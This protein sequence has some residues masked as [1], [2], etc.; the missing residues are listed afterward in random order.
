VTTV[1]RSWARRWAHTASREL[2]LTMVTVRP[3]P[4][5]AQMAPGAPGVAG[6][7]PMASTSSRVSSR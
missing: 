2:L 1:L 5:S 3:L 4:A 7:D 6:A